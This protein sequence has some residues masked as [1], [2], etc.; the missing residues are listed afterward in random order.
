MRYTLHLIVMV[1]C[2]GALAVQ[3]APSRGS[4]KSRSKGKEKTEQRMLPAVMYR[5]N[6]VFSLHEAAWAGDVAVIEQRLQ[7]GMDANEQNSAGE[8]PLHVAARY[9][10]KDCVAALIKAGASATVRNKKDELPQDLTTSAEVKK[11]LNRA[12]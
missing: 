2:L 4:K 3:A 12:R 5:S 9:N 10:Q 1:C 11:M 7:E 8:T 6:G